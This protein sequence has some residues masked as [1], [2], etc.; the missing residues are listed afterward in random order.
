M[1][2]AQLLVDRLR[3]R[4]TINADNI[5]VS[6][7]LAPSLQKG[8]AA[9]RL[10]VSSCYVDVG[11]LNT[12]TDKVM[13]DR[14]EPACGYDPTTHTRYGVFLKC[15]KEYLQPLWTEVQAALS[16]WQLEDEV[17]ETL[18][19]VYLEGKLMMLSGTAY[20][21]LDEFKLSITKTKGDFPI[22]A[23]TSSSTEFKVGLFIKPILIPFSLYSSTTCKHRWS[24]SP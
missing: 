13:E 24:I 22:F 12:T 23:I 19:L 4:L 14:A 9:N 16:G 5:T 3:E 8:F 20:V 7:E 21:W 11:V 15:P 6:K 2:T 17:L 10:Y 1:I 18:P